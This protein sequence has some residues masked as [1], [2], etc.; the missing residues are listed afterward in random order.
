MRTGAAAGKPRSCLRRLTFLS[1]CHA[2]VKGILVLSTCEASD[3]REA[4][5][6][7]CL[8]RAAN[9]DRASCEGV[10]GCW[11]LPV[12]LPQPSSF[13]ALVCR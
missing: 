12:P 8:M 6:S 2:A 10:F 1:P 3:S 7:K 4:G 9:I 11:L 13:S 5:L